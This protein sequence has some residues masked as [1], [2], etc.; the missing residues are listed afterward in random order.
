MSMITLQNDFHNT[1]T[2]LR[3]DLGSSLSKSQIRRARKNLCGISECTCGGN[4]GE[5]GNQ[6]VEIH[7]EGWNDDGE[8]IR[9]YALADDPL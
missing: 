4:L 5:R 9:I 2:T 7:H 8:D 6:G 3:C 1:N